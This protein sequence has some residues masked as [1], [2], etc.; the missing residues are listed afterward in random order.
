MLPKLAYSRRMNLEKTTGMLVDTVTEKQIVRSSHIEGR[1]CCAEVA[2]PA[3]I[4]FTD[5]NSR[6]W[7][8]LLLV[9]R[10][11]VTHDGDA[12]DDVP[13]TKIGARSL[14]S[15]SV[16][17]K[18]DRL[19]YS[20]NFHGYLAG[21]RARMIPEIFRKENS[22]PA[23][24]RTNVRTTLACKDI[25][26]KRFKTLNQDFAK[27][28]A[29]LDNTDHHLPEALHYSCIYSLMIDYADA[30]MESTDTKVTRFNRM[31]RSDNLLVHFMECAAQYIE[32][33]TGV[34]FY[35]NKLCVSESYLSQVIRKKTNYSIGEVL[36]SFRYERLLKYV[37]NPELSLKQIAYKMNF[38][39]QSALSK[40]FKRHNGLSPLAY[41]KK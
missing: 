35:A 21:V 10:G 25:D 41:R 8:Y 23:I 18:I 15:I 37:N 29:A 5:K 13:L 30:V 7:H 19:I 38:P 36:A 16:N 32:S 39:D 24:I 1:Y 11:E 17:T 6:E 14:L 27:M 22:F 12:A 28:M 34:A 9:N 31:N 3:Y 26:P 33:E 2:G 4:E 40:F 20:K